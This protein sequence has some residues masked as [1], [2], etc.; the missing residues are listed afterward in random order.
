MRLKKKI[1]WSFAITKCLPSRI[2]SKNHNSRKRV[3]KKPSIIN[4]NF[5]SFIVHPL[6]TNVLKCRRCRGGLVVC[7]SAVR[8]RDL[9]GGPPNAVRRCP[10]QMP[11]IQKRD[12][13]VNRAAVPK[14]I[15]RSLSRTLPPVNFG[16]LIISTT[17]SGPPVNYNYYRGEQRFF[18][19][20]IAIQTTCLLL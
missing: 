10:V 15:R 14:G 12:T 3:Q 2:S 17:C 8:P 19:L 1:F 6:K 4:G 11:F 18:V 9:C 20:K 16:V 7:V 13:R 5:I